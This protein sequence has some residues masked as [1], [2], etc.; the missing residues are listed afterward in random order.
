VKSV[1]AM[2]ALRGR[3]Y[4]GPVADMDAARAA[5]AKA[6]GESAPGTRLGTPETVSAQG[7]AAE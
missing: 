4:T 1:F 7:S 2:E 6:R 5:L 3:P